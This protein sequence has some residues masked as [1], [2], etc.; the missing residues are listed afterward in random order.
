MQAPAPALP[1]LPIVP[2]LQTISRV[3]GGVANAISN[4]TGS[5]PI[6]N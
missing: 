5:G 6:N 2:I 1:P 3:L 4:L